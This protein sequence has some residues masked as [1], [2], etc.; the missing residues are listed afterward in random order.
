MKIHFSDDNRAFDANN[1][2]TGVIKINSN[3]DISAYSLT[4]KLEMVDTSRRKKKSEIHLLKRK[5]FEK[6]IVVQKFDDNICHAGEQS[7]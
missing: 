2:I 6:A 4:L 3:R 7:F 1:P 5:G